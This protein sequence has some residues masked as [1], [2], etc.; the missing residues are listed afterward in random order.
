MDYMGVSTSLQHGGCGQ[1]G[2]H[3]NCIFQS[4]VFSQFLP[5]PTANFPVPTACFGDVSY[6]KVTWQTHLV[7]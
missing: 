3:S 2:R 7:P 6:A 4:P 1:Q 5:C